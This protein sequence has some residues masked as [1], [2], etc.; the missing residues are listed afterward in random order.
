MVTGSIQRFAT[1]TASSTS[2]CCAAVTVG[3]V[4][5][6]TV[7]RATSVD[8]SIRASGVCAPNICFIWFCI[9]AM[10]PESVGSMPIC[11]H[12]FWIASPAP[13][14]TAVAAQ[15]THQRVEVGELAALAARPAELADELAEVGHTLRAAAEQL[16]EHRAQLAEVT[17]VLIVIVIAVPRV[18][19]GRRLRATGRPPEKPIRGW[20]GAP[21]NGSA[22]PASCPADRPAGR[23]AAGRRRRSTRPRWG[24]RA[25]SRPVR[26]GGLV[27]IGSLGHG[28]SSGPSM[29]WEDVPLDN[30]EEYPLSSPVRS[31]QGE[32]PGSRMP[33]VAVAGPGAVVGVPALRIA[34][35][36]AAT[37]GQADGVAEVR[38]LAPVRGMLEGARWRVVETDG[39]GVS[40]ELAGVDVLVWVATC[41][42][43][44][45]ALARRP[46]DRRAALLRT[47]RALT[48]AASAAGVGHVLVVTSAEVFGAF[49]D[50]EVPLPD[51]APVRAVL[52]EGFVGDLLAVEALVEESREHHPD[53]RFTLVRPAA[54]VG[55]GVDTALT[56]YFEAPRLLSIKTGSP[57]WQLCHVDDLASGVRLRGDRR[58]G[59]G[60]RP[61]RSA[62]RGR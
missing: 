5:D 6:A 1:R 34:R 38:V 19:A 51:H 2:R 31:S 9:M 15:L 36:L 33:V 50:N 12:R 47:G 13:A 49:P 41:T 16:L 54:L 44:A 60:R 24:S 3:S 62:A 48:L 40:A 56:R 21:S 23:P 14:M 29:L 26:F 17:V 30:H 35:L 20:L 39:P 52:D 18:P 42:D 58:P 57:A 55:A 4:S 25:R 27:A 43:L 8:I 28:G 10:T 53:V 7:L 32:P 11:F 22:G 45:E 37:R 46:A 59:P 61:S